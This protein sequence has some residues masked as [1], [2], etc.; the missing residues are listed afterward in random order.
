MRADHAFF[1]LSSDKPISDR[2][3]WLIMKSRGWNS[4]GN[5]ERLPNVL[6]RSSRT[7]WSSGQV[8]Q[9]SL[10]AA[11]KPQQQLLSG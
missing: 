7:G 8:L 1:H 6:L 3:R 9:C 2:R 5:T 4:V 11:R 10:L